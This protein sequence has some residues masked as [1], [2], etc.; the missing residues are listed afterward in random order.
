MSGQCWRIELRSSQKGYAIRCT[1]STDIFDNSVRDR[2]SNSRGVCHRPY[3]FTT[4]LVVGYLKD[5][6]TLPHAFPLSTE[7]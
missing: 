3:P 1:I 2:F 4:P 7:K 6:E 5:N